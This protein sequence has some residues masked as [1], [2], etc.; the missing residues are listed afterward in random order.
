MCAIHKEITINAPAS[1][2]WDILINF[3]AYTSWNPFIVY[4]S[5]QAA[6]GNQLEIS[7]KQANDKVMS[8]K[9]IIT[10]CKKPQELQW[11]GIMGAGF[12]FNALHSF[13]LKEA[14]PN[15]TTFI[16]SERFTGLLVPIFTLLGLKKN[17]EAGF[18]LF[19]QALKE[20]A[21]NSNSAVNNKKAR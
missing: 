18:E 5:G 15:T 11:R 2:V 6:L 12:L 1:R 10:I 14:S 13:E 8:F 9:P 7:I 3:E 17:A 4:A 20:L 16:H 19:N 21:E